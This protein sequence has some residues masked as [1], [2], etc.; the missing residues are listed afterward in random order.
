MKFRMIMYAICKTWV[1]NKKNQCMR[2]KL[3]NMI[4]QDGQNLSSKNKNPKWT[5]HI[6]EKKQ[7]HPFDMFPHLP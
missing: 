7:Q 3:Y 4:I 2:I 1:F 5:S 6:G